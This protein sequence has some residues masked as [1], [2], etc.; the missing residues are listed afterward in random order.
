MENLYNRKT[1]KDKVEQLT[2]YKWAYITFVKYEE[3]GFYK[4]H[5]TMANGNREVPVY[6]DKEVN[7]FVK[8]IPKLVKQGL[9]RIK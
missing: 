1:F 4:P 8:D 7:K 5:G 3:K 9:M 2:G 6:T